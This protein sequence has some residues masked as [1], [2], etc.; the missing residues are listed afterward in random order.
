MK[1]VGKIL[2]LTMF[3]L[4][5]GIGSNIF[6]QK[7]VEVFDGRE[8][9]SFEDVKTEGSKFFDELIKNPETNIKA[10]LKKHFSADCGEIS[11][12]LKTT[13]EGSFTRPKSSQKAFVYYGYC[14]K[15]IFS[16]ATSIMITE[17]DKIV[18]NQ[19]YSTDNVKKAKKLS[20]INKNGLDEL[21]IISSY[22]LDVIVMDSGQT[23]LDIVEFSSSDSFNYLGR[24][25]TYSW[26]GLSAAEDE[27]GIPAY[28]P[29]SYKIYVKP[30]TDPIFSR[31][32][33]RNIKDEK[34]KETKWILTKKLEDFKLDSKREN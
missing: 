33:Y 13:L 1:Q 7:P 23:W 20:D 9:F 19:F 15:D 6:G 16:Q 11:I 17:N 4:L 18:F 34:T 27:K 22:G 31:E 21:V 5:G 8:I 2:F 24:A 25:T 14:K 32:T 28:I 10:D 12:G 30:S 29:W 3:L 26:S